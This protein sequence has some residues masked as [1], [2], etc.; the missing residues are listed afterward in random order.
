MTI[1]S[2]VRSLTPLTICTIYLALLNNSTQ[3]R[4]VCDHFSY[5]FYHA[6]FYA[7]IYLLTIFKVSNI[8][9]NLTNYST[10]VSDITFETS[11]YTSV[12]KI[13]RNFFAFTIST[14]NYILNASQST[15]L[16]Y[17]D[18]LLRFCLQGT[19]ENSVD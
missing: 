12:N 10:H 9:D 8:F 14:I 5:N 3:K 19:K 15:L 6:V 17:Y 7:Y 16:C 18:K 11:N 1:W 2:Q 13:P 4:V